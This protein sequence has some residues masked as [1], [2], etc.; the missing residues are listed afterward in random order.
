LCDVRHSLQN[1][2]LVREH[3]LGTGT[4]SSI[5]G[6]ISITG[7]ITG[8]LVGSRLG[9]KV[10][11]VVKGGRL[12]VGGAAISIG[13][14]LLG[15]AL[16]VDGIVPMVVLMLIAATVSSIAI[17][18]CTAGFAD[19][20]GANVRGVGFALLQLCMTFGAAFGPLVVGIASDASGSLIIAMY[21]L[22]VPMVVGGLLIVGSRAAYEREA[23]RVLDDARNA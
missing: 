6:V 12:L 16:L 9:R 11:G 5:S 3:G 7:V 14:L 1:I 15:T 10:H 17:P 13:S 18:T 19:V 21:V 20:V 23:A 2:V 22:I 8:T 4:A